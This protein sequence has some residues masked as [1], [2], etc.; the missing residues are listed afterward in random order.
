MILDYLYSPPTTCAGTTTSTAR[1]AARRTEVALCYII[2]AVVYHVIWCPCS[3]LHVTNDIYMYMPICMCIYIY[4][5]IHMCIYIYI[6]IH[7]YIYIYT[8]TYVMRHA[9]LGWLQAVVLRATNTATQ[10]LR[11]C[12]SRLFEQLFE[13][14][15]VAALCFLRSSS[16]SFEL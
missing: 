6:Y 5:Y 9:D 12:S 7:I 11:L 8:Y 15:P 3:M 10:M 14:F 1:R 4:I 16:S 13:L 2:N